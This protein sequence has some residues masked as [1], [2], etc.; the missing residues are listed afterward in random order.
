L[1][2]SLTYHVPPAQLLPYIAGGYVLS[3]SAPVEYSEVSSLLGQLHWQLRG[4]I[5]YD[6]ASSRFRPVPRN[7]V[8]GATTRSPDVRFH[9]PFKM[10]GVGLLPAGWR[11]WLRVPATHCQNLIAPM[12]AFAPELASLGPMLDPDMPDAALAAAVY[13]RLASALPEATDI[14]RVIFAIDQWLVRDAREVRSLV[15]DLAISHRQLNRIALE[16][17]GAPLRLLGVKFR[18]LRCAARLASGAATGWSDAMIDEF[19]DQPHLIKNFR[20]FVG[21]TPSAFLSEQASFNR[22][23]MRQRLIIRADNPLAAWG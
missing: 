6:D 19:C 1:P 23:I 17:H 7:A 2:L 5:A 21:A 10:V 20:R 8:I 18:T 14:E 15:D 3:S 22:E 16:T 4:R 12:A 9:G 11:R 13:A